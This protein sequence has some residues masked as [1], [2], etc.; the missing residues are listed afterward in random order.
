MQSYYLRD[1]ESDARQR[2]LLA[3][4][5][6][7]VICVRE[8][9]AS[10][11]ETFNGVNITRI[12]ILRRRAT[13]YRYMLE[14]TT[15]FV[16]VAFLLVLRMRKRYDVIHVNN[17]PDFLVFSTLIPK[18]FGAKIV[19]DVHDP[20][21]E[22]FIS[23]YEIREDSPV[24]R[25]LRWQQK[26]SLRYCH[27]ALTVTEVMKELLQ[28]QSGYTPISVVLNVPDER[29]F[30]RPQQDLSVRKSEEQFTLLYT[31]TISARY[32]LDIAVEAVALL[33]DRI[34]GLRLRLV[35][36]GDDLPGLGEMAERGSQR[37]GAVLS[38]CSAFRGAGSDRPERHRYIPSS[39]RRLYSVVLLHQSGRVCELGSSLR[40]QQ[41]SHDGAL[42]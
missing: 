38:A 12:P 32:G 36:E 35:G 4:Y 18:M 33:K 30:E 1:P 5:Q 31:G 19:L 41:N 17:M 29:V 9:G 16:C 20:M 27:H 40:G 37:H 25:L 8:K 6:V 23:K 11:K 15:F 26:I 21:A 2:R 7:D 42:F 34:P 13:L 22:V 3:G 28:R 10:T 39:G 14:Y 24:V